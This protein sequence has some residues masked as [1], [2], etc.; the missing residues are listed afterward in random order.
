MT[1]EQSELLKLL[2]LF[3]SICEQ[4]NLQYYL[5]GGTLLGAIRHQGFIPWDDDID[6]MMPIED[7]KKFIQFAPE[8]PE[9]IV[10]QSDHTD[11]DYPFLFVEFCNTMIPFKT[12]KPHGPMGIYIDVFPLIPSRPPTKLAV[13]YF[14][15]ISVIGYI[16]QVKCGWTTF[17]PYKKS[18]AK[19]G[20]RLLGNLSVSKLR[21]LR[22]TLIKKLFAKDS[23]YFLSPGGGHKDATEFYPQKWFTN[24]V[25]AIFE[26][27]QQPAPVGW[28]QYLEQL[29]GNYM[30]PP[31]E[32]NRKS[33]HRG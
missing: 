17:V 8:F 24:T 32:K 20:Y 30:I 23:E 15:I 3:S 11:K 10:I 16:L 33:L 31:D 5:A 26:G 19:I 7:Y 27:R 13:F 14:N 22:C 29:Y 6:I 1:Q 18:W 2:D 21:L 25:V 28:E 9:G 12:E 4:N